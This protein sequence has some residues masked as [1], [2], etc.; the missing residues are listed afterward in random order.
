MTSFLILCLAISL[1]CCRVD[2]GSS[3]QKQT[4]RSTAPNTYGRDEFLCPIDQQCK[5]ANQRCLGPSSQVCAQNGKMEEGC[6]YDA[7]RQQ[8]EYYKGQAPL[9]SSSSSISRRKR[10]YFKNHKP[11]HVFV[12]YR[13]FTFEFG[14]YRAQILDKN[15]PK[16]K[17][18][19]H[20]TG[21]VNKREYMGTSDCT[22]GELQTFVQDRNRK[23]NVFTNNCQHFASGLITILSN[24]CAKIRAYRPQRKRD[25][26][27]PDDLAAY[28]S[29]ITTGN[30]SLSSNGDSNSPNG[31]VATETGLVWMY[32]LVAVMTTSFVS[33]G[34]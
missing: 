32:S 17:Y 27:I 1:A 19:P 3:G 15:D 9:L 4:C 33:R 13:G 29:Q 8:Y 6:N 14:G 2:G 34:L 12:D 23:Y 30:C 7:S 11:Y 20:G 21:T 22:Y 25:T 10:E 24:N 5:P 28:F 16:Y 26:A 31:S 18:G